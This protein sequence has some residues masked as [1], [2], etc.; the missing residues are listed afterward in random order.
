MDCSNGRRH[1]TIDVDYV[2]KKREQATTIPFVKS[3]S[4]LSPH[5]SRDKHCE[6]KDIYARLELMVAKKNVEGEGT[7]Q[8]KR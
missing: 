3:I 2:H 6:I 5:R 1:T 8:Q 7:G 4:R